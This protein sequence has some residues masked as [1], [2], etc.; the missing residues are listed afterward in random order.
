MHKTHHIFSPTI[1]IKYY[2]AM[3]DEQNF[4]GQ[5]V[6]NDMRT[7]DN[8]RKITTSQDYPYFKEHYKLIAI[9]LRKQQAGNTIMFFIIEKA[10]VTNLDFSQ[11]TV[12]ALSVYFALI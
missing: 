6:K 5:P 1:D 2:N 9:D 8:I 12:R 3:I 11:G 7:Y 10:K 4:F